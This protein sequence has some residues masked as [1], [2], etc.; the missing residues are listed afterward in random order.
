MILGNPS[1]AV[2]NNLLPNLPTNAGVGLAGASSV[3][4][5]L[6]ISVSS[7]VDTG[8]NGL[9]GGNQLLSQTSLH[10]LEHMLNE[11]LN[12]GEHKEGAE[13]GGLEHKTGVETVHKGTLIDAHED[14]PTEHGSAGKK[15]LFCYFIAK[16]NL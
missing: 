15:S 13:T 2:Y 14:S 7:V 16:H 9:L 4:N 3:A 5:N 8:L 10:G 6:P 12:A 1:A 11:K